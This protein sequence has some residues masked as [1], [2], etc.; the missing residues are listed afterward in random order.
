MILIISN[1]SILILTAA[2]LFLIAV[3]IHDYFYG[4]S[5][6][7]ELVLITLYILLFAAVIP[8]LCVWLF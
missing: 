6:C 5:H 8:R 7:H 2:L 1:I 3:E 4:E